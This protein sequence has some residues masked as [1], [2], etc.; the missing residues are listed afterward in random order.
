[1]ANGGV[2]ENVHI[3]SIT[4]NCDNASILVNI[5]QLSVNVCHNE[6]VSLYNGALLEDLNHNFG[7]KSLIKKSLL[8]I[9]SWC[10]YD[11]S[12]YSA[13]NIYKLNIFYL[14]KIFFIFI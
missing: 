9:K 2:D 14:K 1:M 10:S 7:R 4:F 3:K 8:L 13:G 12:Q 6:L 11:S 5:N